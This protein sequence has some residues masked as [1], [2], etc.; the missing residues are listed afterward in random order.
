MTHPITPRKCTPMLNPSV[1]SRKTKYN[2]MHTPSDDC[3]KEHSHS[4]HSYK[5]YYLML[6]QGFNWKL[7]QAN[8]GTEEG[9]SSVRGVISEKST[10][11]LLWHS[12]RYYSSDPPHLRLEVKFSS[13][14]I[15]SSSPH[16]TVNTKF[17][18][19]CFTKSQQSACARG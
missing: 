8:A 9:K 3:C 1:I 2:N 10:S 7:N 6:F 19:Y 11:V 13:T 18:T 15:I 4:E 12:L 16:R 14:F 5:Y 17:Q